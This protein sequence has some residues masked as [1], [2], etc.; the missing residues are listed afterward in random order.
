MS[1]LTIPTLVVKRFKKLQRDFLWGR[2]VQEFKYH[3]VASGQIKEG[4]V[5]W[6]GLA[7]PTGLA[8]Q[9]VL[10]ICSRERFCMRA[11]FP[12]FFFYCGWGD[13]IVNRFSYHLQGVFLGGYH[14]PC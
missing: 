8:R 1:V 14:E 10:V 5:S 4:G 13:C 6:E 3:L 7:F 9:V 2:Y 11:I 12:P